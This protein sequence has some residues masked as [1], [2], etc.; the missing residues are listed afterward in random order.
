MKTLC[1]IGDPVE[2]S[3][4]PVMFNA[5]FK[6][7]GLEKQF[8]YRRMKI[9]KGDLKGF[10]ERVRTGEITGASVTMPCKEAIASLLDE[11][12]EEAKFIKAVNTVYNSGGKVVG[13]NTDGMGCL[14]AL[15]EAGVSILGKNVVLLG[16][17][18]A[19]KAIA[20]TLVHQGVDRLVILNRTVSK[21]ETVA[22]VLRK[23]TNVDAGG[24]DRLKNA[25]RDADVL[26]NATSVGMRGE[27]EKKT[28]VTAELMRPDLVVED[29]VYVPRRTRLLEEALKAGARIV[30]GKGML[31]YQGAEQFKIF[32]G[33][34]PPIDAMR[35]ALSVALNEG[36]CRKN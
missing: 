8:T 15:E 32:T 27:H 7:L 28:L 29:I 20:Y 30:E 16:A 25:L 36:C 12:S 21:A 9:Q 23:Q 4:S 17:G 22:R 1:V 14:K 13:C 35:E 2:H 6:A 24:L 31:V 26:I 18:G 5:A 3:L 11:L 34:E 33:K 10:V 19:A